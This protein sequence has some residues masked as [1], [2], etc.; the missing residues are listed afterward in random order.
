MR[1]VLSCR[2]KNSTFYNFVTD[3]GI[4]YI[5]NPT[6]ESIRNHPTIQKTIQNL[7]YDVIDISWY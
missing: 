2:N 7:R 4:E 5:R 1:V 3:V 6:A